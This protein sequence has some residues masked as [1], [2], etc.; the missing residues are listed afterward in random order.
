MAGYDATLLALIFW[1]NPTC[2]TSTNRRT[3]PHTNHSL[4][5]HTCCTTGRGH[6]HHHLPRHGLPSGPRHQG[7]S[8][9]IPGP[10][11]WL[12]A[13]PA[14]ALQL[15]DVRQVRGVG[16]GGGLSL[17][18]VRGLGLWDACAGPCALLCLL[19]ALRHR[20]FLALYSCVAALTA[21]TNSQHAG[22]LMLVSAG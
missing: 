10:R 20:A 22:P 5:H 21:A 9:R 16:D 13:R 14:G 3:N 11:V 6:P 12:Q 7:L 8:A 2:Q 15:G 19:C 18:G 1:C 17:L 4:R